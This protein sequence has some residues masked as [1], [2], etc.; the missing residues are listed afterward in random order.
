M[1]GSQTLQIGNPR[2]SAASPGA[3]LITKLEGV[4]KLEDKWK[5][6]ESRPWPNP[7]PRGA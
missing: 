7:R 4:S 2:A 3:L 6:S 5:G 1:R